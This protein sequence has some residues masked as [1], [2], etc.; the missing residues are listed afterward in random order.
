MLL[1]TNRTDDFRD[2]EPEHP[3]CLAVVWPSRDVRGEGLG[4]RG[5]K[6]EIPL[7]L[8]PAVVKDLAECTWYGKANQLSRE[9][10]VHWDIIDEVAEASWKMQD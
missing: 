6:N 5:E 8:D 4:V 9:H 1:G 3:D 2:V 10:G 7:F